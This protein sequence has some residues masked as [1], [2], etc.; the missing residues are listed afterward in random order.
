VA[1]WSGHPSFDFAVIPDVIA[2]SKTTMTESCSG[3]FPD[4]GVP[5]SHLH[6][7]LSRLECLL[8]SFPHIV[9]GSRGAYKNPGT[10]M[11]YSRPEAGCENRNYMASEIYGPVR[12][13]ACDRPGL[14]NCASFPARSSANR[15][16]FAVF[17][18]VNASSQLIAEDPA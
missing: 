14:A 12:G 4:D 5:I 10:L 9:L 6:E 8:R 1:E 11:R 13:D 17:T 3:P 15:S 16:K 2:A 18:F 7:P